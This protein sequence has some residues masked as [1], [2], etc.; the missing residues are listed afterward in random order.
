[1][2]EAGAT[3]S[4]VG[5]RCQSGKMLYG[6]MQERWRKKKISREGEKK[7]KEKKKRGDTVE[8]KE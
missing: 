8:R 5:Q 4:H 3:T 1:M 6:C 2:K 7:K